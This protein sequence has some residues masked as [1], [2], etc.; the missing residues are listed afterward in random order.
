MGLQNQNIIFFSQMQFD[1]ALESTNYTL[2]KHLAK[3]NYVLYVDRPYT[4]FDYFKFRKTEGYRTR[5][6]HFF[7]AKK[8][9]IDT[10]N[11]NLKIIIV[12]PLPSINMLPEGWFYRSMLRF[13]E[14]ITAQRLK[15]VIKNQSITS[16]IYINSYNVAFPTLH[17]KLDPVL[18]VYHC[19]DPLVEPYQTRHGLMSEDI[20]VKNVDAVISTSKELRNQKAA[21]NANSFFVPNAANIAHSQQALQSDLKIAAVLD[22][23]QKPIIGYLGNI[24]RRIDY[25]LV[26]QVMAMN[27]DKSFVFVGPID[28]YYLKESDFT[29]PNLYFTGP[30]PYSQMPAVLK[31]FDV[32]IIPFKKDEVSSHI[33]PLKLF[34]YLGS[35]RPVVS[36]DFNPD[37]KEFTGDAVAYCEDAAEFSAAIAAALKDNDNL[38]QKRLAIAAENTWEHRAEEFKNVL[39]KLLISKNIDI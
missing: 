27:P 33:F 28:N 38:K 39:C 37:L 35:G 5:R 13:N 14:R 2:A 19:V 6:P 36:S 1:S 12:P 4:W 23:V 31:G 15:K 8:C 30:V 26:K 16:Y 3:D 9:I 24:E 25:S 20:L 34:E 29:G 18:A 32:A 21:L 10:E 17:K 11:P 7:S 22:G